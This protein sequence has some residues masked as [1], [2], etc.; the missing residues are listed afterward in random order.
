MM[1][2]ERSMC[3]Y[4]GPESGAF[5]DR[6]DPS[7]GGAPLESLSVGASQDRAVVSFT[8]D[9][10]DRAGARDERDDGGLVAFADDAAGCDV[11]ARRRGPRCWWRT[12][13]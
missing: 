9:E 12:L 10:V 3:G 11:R 2:A 8:D 13:R 7:V 5:G 1:N 6:G 4:T